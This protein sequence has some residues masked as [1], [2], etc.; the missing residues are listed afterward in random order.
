MFPLILLAKCLNMFKVLLNRWYINETLT[1][2]TGAHTHLRSR[3]KNPKLSQLF[4]S[5]FLQIFQRNL[6]CS[7]RILHL[8]VLLKLLQAEIRHCR[9]YSRTVT[10]SFFHGK[11]WLELLQGLLSWI[12]S[13]IHLFHHHYA[14]VSRLHGQRTPDSTLSFLEGW[15]SNLVF[16]KIRMCIW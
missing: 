11:C 4:I 13:F 10:L 2:N 9:A 14:S 5:F 16:V 12:T 1:E 15:I 7:S 3:I 6:C 8:Q